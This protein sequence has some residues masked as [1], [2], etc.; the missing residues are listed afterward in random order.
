MD[1]IER[2]IVRIPQCLTHILR[3]RCGPRDFVRQDTVETDVVS[4]LA[5]M[6]PP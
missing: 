5:M 1:H 4:V 6:K 3:P 2:I